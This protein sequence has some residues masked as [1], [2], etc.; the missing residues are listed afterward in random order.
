[1]L[2]QTSAQK[3]TGPINVEPDTAVDRFE[4]TAPQRFCFEEIMRR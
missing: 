3:P 4:L 2:T 1:M